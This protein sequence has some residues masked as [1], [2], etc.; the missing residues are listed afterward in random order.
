[1]MHYPVM[2][3]LKGREVVII[4]GGK[5][6]S[7]KIRGLLDSKALITVISPIITAEISELEAEK[8]LKWKKKT[9][10]KEDI[11]NAFLVI[12]ATDNPSVN[13]SVLANVKENQLINL[14]NQPEQST[15]LVPAKFTRGKL[16]VSISTD[17]AFPGLSKK[18]KEKLADQFDDEYESYIQFLENCRH[19]V[20]QTIP[21]PKVKKKV[22]TKLL[23]VN[24]LE[25]DGPGRIQAFEQIMNEVD[26]A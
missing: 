14:V 20:L 24:L 16:T 22:L 25:M 7:R 18:I 5:V 9:F 2:L 21:N 10:E 1:M 23:Q 8:K 11:A 26:E 3:N 12:A 4:G 13:A 6:A 19:E 17:G 15:F